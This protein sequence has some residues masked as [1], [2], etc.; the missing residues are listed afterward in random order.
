MS[1]IRT[2]VS[3]AMLAMGVSVA[4]CAG[5]THDGSVAGDPQALTECSSAGTWAIKITTPV[6]WNQTFVIQGG[7]GTITNFAKS[8]RTQN[9]LTIVDTAKI[10]GIETPPYSSTPTFGNEKYGVSFAPE[11]FDAP[12]MPSFTLNGTLSANTE[13]ASFTAT[14]SAALIGATMANPTTDPW[15][16]NGAALTA[17]DADG[18]GNVGITGIPMSGNGFIQPPV[19]PTRTIRAGKVFATFR[20]VLTASGTVKSCT[21]VEGVGDIAMINNKAAIDQHVLGCQHQDGAACAPAEF[22]LLDGAAPV[23]IPTD[24]ATITMVKLA[25]NATCA[26]VRA[27]AF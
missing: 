19:N 6:K 20:N 13:G 9:G 11:V 4:A 16:S 23:Y 8:V 15:P 2:A 12:S 18:D 14:P 27:A 25:D 22:K 26:D 7:S 10:C 3:L 17:V 21:R 24:K 5:E 1:Y